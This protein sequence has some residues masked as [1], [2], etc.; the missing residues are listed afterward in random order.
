MK[1]KNKGRRTHTRKYIGIT[2]PRTAQVL[3]PAII[4][5]RLPTTN[6]E[7]VRRRNREEERNNTHTYKALH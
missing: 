5:Y 3:I 4:I 1:N 2:P 7:F 6:K